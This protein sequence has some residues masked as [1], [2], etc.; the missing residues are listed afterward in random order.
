M[1][2]LQRVFPGCAEHLILLQNTCRLRTSFFP[3]LLGG[4]VSEAKVCLFSLVTAVTSFTFVIYVTS[5]TCVTFVTNVTAI[6]FLTIVTAI[7]S[8]TSV[9]YV[10]LVICLT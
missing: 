4:P 6:A 3:A 10:T 1:S 2:Y 7:T 5:V 9:T 8:F